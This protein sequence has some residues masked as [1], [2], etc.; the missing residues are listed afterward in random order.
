MEEEFWPWYN[1][2]YMLQT[3]SVYRELPEGLNLDL[4]F[5]V[6]QIR[7]MNRDNTIRYKGRLYQLLS[8]S[9]ISTLSDKEVEVCEQV[10][11]KIKILYRGSEV[12]F[13]EIMDE[14]KVLDEEEILSRRANMSECRVKKEEWRP[15]SQHPWRKIFKLKKKMTP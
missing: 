4:V 5:S 8:G 10:E 1:N 2:R 15:S 6:K 12:Q 11:G 7:K 3:E 14:K 9:G 13:E